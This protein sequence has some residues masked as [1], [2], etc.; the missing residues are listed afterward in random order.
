M[1]W[2]QKYGARVRGY[3]RENPGNALFYSYMAVIIIVAIAVV[4]FGISLHPVSVVGSSMVPTY[5]DGDIVGTRIPQAY[6]EIAKGD[7]IVFRAD[8]AKTVIKRV[9]ALEDDIIQVRDG[10][11]VVNGHEETG[12][13]ELMEDPGMFDTPFIVPDGHVVAFGDNRNHSTDSRAF[14]AVPFE[15]IRGI[16]NRDIFVR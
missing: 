9:V 1:S 14:G 10:I 15:D 4:I 7:I 6:G 13:Y 3:I 16:V 12:D 5:H 2:W 8:G 11:L